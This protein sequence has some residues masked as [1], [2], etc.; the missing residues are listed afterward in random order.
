MTTCRSLYGGT[1]GGEV[2]GTNESGDPTTSSPR[3]PS[4]TS[5]VAVLDTQPSAPATE[6][7]LGR[8]DDPDSTGVEAN[9]R[10]TATT[11]SALALLFVAQLVTVALGVRSVLTLHI[12]IGLLLAPPVALKVGSVAW[13]LIRYHR[14]DRAYQSKAAPRALL[15]V[16]GP[17]LVGLTALLFASG[18]GLVVG[19]ASLHATALTI[20]KTSFYPW[21]VVL[22]VHVALHCRQASRDTRRE[23][24]RQGRAEVPGAQRRLPALLGS[25]AIGVVLAVGLAGTASTYLAHYPHR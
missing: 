20:H 12:V 24:S 21:L 10:L 23:L 5:P 8:G 25:V 18:I 22:V 1:H 11:G 3:P 19:P 9:A 13:R 7:R 6:S 15:R 16:L 14:G 4:A 2:S 17:I